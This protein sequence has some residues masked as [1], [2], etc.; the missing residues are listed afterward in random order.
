MM[1]EKVETCVS[2]VN[3]NKNYLLIKTV[4]MCMSTVRA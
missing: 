1:T 4:W 3:A 2:R